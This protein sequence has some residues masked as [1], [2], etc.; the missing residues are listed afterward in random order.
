MEEYNEQLSLLKKRIIQT[1][2]QLASEFDEL[3]LLINE[4]YDENN[5]GFPE[6]FDFLNI[7]E[8]QK[9]NQAFWSCYE[10]L[11]PLLDQLM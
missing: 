10:R 7:F 4:V 9:V 2:Q 5:E 3:D 6:D 1:M 8:N 11:F